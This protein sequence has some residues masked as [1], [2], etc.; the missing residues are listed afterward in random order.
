[1]II[2]DAVG[3]LFLLVIATKAW[4]A[5]VEVEDFGRGIVFDGDVVQAFTAFAEV[6]RPDPATKSPAKAE[7]SAAEEEADAPAAVAPET[8]SEPP[9]DAPT[10]PVES[11]VEPQAV[12]VT[13]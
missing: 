7:N 10:E 9:V 1:M 12:T 6:V 2:V 4:P 13:P 11:D 3:Q 5:A 8:E